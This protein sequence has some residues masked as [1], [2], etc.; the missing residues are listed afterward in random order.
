M[1]NL[2]TLAIALFAFNSFAMTVDVISADFKVEN[3]IAEKTLCVTVVKVSESGEQFG[4]VEDIG[5]CFYARMA[6]RNPLAPLEINPKSLGPVTSELNDHL[7][8]R[9]TGLEFYFSD[10]E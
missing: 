2:F 6:K 5:D 7:Q 10:G 3:E 9:A 8:K 4:I 1:K